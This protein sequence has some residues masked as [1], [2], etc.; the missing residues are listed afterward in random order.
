MPRTHPPT[1]PSILWRSRGGSALLLLLVWISIPLCL[2]LVGVVLLGWAAGQ[3]L[4]IHAEAAF[5][6]VRRS[7]LP[8]LIAMTLCPLG[9]A[10]AGFWTWQVGEAVQP[11]WGFEHATQFALFTTP[12]V[13]VLVGWSLAPFLFAAVISVDP[14][15]PTDLRHTMSLALRV[16]QAIPASRRLFGI[17][18]A[19]TVLIGPVLCFTWDGIH[20]RGAEFWVWGAAGLFVPVASA[21]LV[22]NYALVRDELGE[23]EGELPNI[24]SGMATF[25]FGCLVLS[26]WAMFRGSPTSSLILLLLWFAIAH[27]I[28]RFIRAHQLS[29]LDPLR[30]GAAPGRHALVGTLRVHGDDWREGACVVAGEILLNVSPRARVVGDASALS[31]GALVTV[32]GD[33]EASLAGFRQGADRPW[34][35]DARLFVGALESVVASATSY[36]TRITYGA[37][38]IA[39]IYAALTIAL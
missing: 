12:V 10:I 18:I 33:F 39:S 35:S 34:P 24:P 3:M 4:S 1:V 15:G 36:A 27:A 21:L 2:V 13:F 8:T 30:D 11:L 22:A 5:G 7:P 23:L 29:R 37:L 9:V 31:N 14:R 38:T 16:T 25:T 20:F 26:V 19:G 28:F 32:V 6:H 17:V